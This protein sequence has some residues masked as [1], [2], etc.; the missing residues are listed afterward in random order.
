MHVYS[1]DLKNRGEKKL[2]C[3]SAVLDSQVTILILI[4]SQY[5][6]LPMITFKNPVCSKHVSIHRHTQTCRYTPPSF[7]NSGNFPGPN[8]A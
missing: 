8:Q 5:Q 6:H 7:A 3:Y 1:H 4:L 2:P